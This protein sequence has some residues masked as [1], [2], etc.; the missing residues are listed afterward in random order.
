MARKMLTADEVATRLE[1]LPGWALEGATLARRFTFGSYGE[2]VAFAVRV[3]LDAERRDHH[4][5]AL[6]IGYRWVRV[7]YTT[8]DV[9]GI[10][11][12]DFE[13][14]GAVNALLG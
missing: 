9:G 3:A 7:A 10:T 6:T 2:G 13:A 4:P 12:R 14:A 11:A 1:E 8:H 5:D